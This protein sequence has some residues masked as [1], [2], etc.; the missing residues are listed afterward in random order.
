MGWEDIIKKQKTEAYY[1][2]M[3]FQALKET[4]KK[5]KNKINIDEYYNTRDYYR[6]AKTFAKIMMNKDSKEELKR[7]SLA[8][9]KRISEEKER[10]SKQ[11][12][13]GIGVSISPYDV[14]DNYQKYPE[15]S[16]MEVI[17]EILEEK[18]GT[19]DFDTLMGGVENKHS[20]IISEKELEAYLK[21]NPSY[22]KLNDGKYTKA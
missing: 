10:Y 5:L 11:S 21:N 15:T 16:L 3:F 14:E 8:R 2:K 13:T 17:D 18:G 4:R 7:N 1:M 19:T 6:D 22:K 12:G 9:A 20:L